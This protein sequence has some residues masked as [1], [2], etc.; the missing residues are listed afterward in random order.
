MQEQKV[1]KT[2]DVF[3]ESLRWES[4]PDFENCLFS[5]TGRLWLV[6]RL[7]YANLNATSFGRTIYTYTK[8]DKRTRYEFAKIIAELFVDN[9]DPDKKKYIYFRDGNQTNNNADNLIWSSNPYM[10]DDENVIWEDLCYAPKSHEISVL[11][12]RQKGG[13]ILNPY[14]TSKGY[15]RVRL[16]SAQHNVDSECLIHIAMAIHF[17]I[18]P[19][20]ATKIFVNHKDGD[21]T[22][23][24]L[25]NLE[26]V[27]QSENTIHARATGLISKI[28][29]GRK[30]EEFIEGKVIASFDSITQVSISLGVKRDWVKGRLHR[31]DFFTLL[32]RTFKLKYP[33]PIEGEIWKNVN[34]LNKEHNARFEVS[35]KGRVRRIRDQ[36][37]CELVPS[38]KY[39]AV[40]FA[41]QLGDADV[42]TQEHFRVHV[43]VAF[44]FLPFLSRDHDVNHKD[45]NKRNNCLENLEILDRAEHNIR[46]NGRPIIGIHKDCAGPFVG[47]R[48]IKCAVRAL[49]T[50]GIYNALKSGNPCED[51]C[52]YYL[53]DPEI[54]AILKA[55]NIRVVIDHDNKRINFL[56]F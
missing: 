37:H 36:R 31:T 49:N 39:H 43:L 6:K 46:D 40:V 18:N 26:W 56:Q 53:D 5:N 30:V 9:P 1:G 42:N 12:I 52:W 32:G 11:G 14:L 51:H 38:G 35:N 47:Y 44:A 24:S 10:L 15:M 19:D 7:R 25:N 8:N 34:T 3:D 17:I 48:S 13:N 41:K 29:V 28:V 27:T 22:N 33:D 54:Q 20:P 50:T 45:R 23:W 16:Y 2:K 55:S 4:H 21:K